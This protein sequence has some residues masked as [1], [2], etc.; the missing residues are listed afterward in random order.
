MTHLNVSANDVHRQQQHLIGLSRGLTIFKTTYDH[1]SGR[2]TEKQACERND[3]IV[4]QGLHALATISLCSLYDLRVF[5]DPQEE[6]RQ[7]WK[8]QRDT[9]DRSYSPEEV[10]RVLSNRDAD[11]QAQFSRNENKL[12]SSSAGP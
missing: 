4:F 12:N 3:V 9:R 8:I 2:F 7:F 6:L 10:L 1:N 5:S 11:R